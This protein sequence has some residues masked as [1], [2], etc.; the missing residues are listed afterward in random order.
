MTK[1]QKTLGDPVMIGRT[2][3]RKCQYRGCENK[4]RLFLIMPLADIAEDGGPG[5][6]GVAIC[7]DCLPEMM[8]YLDENP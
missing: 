1:V 6:G 3:P 4:T 5:L 2:R 8:K 7:G